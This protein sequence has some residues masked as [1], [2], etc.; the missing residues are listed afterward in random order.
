MTE[1]TAHATP[2]TDTGRFDG[3]P[4]N[5]MGYGAM[6]LAGLGEKGAPDPDTAVAVLRRA[7]AWGVNH[8]DTAEFYGD[9]VAND[10]IRAALLPY[11][12]DL[13]L[14]IKVGAQ[15]DAQR[16]LVP[17]QRPEQLRAGVEANLRRL[18]VERLAAVNLRRLE[19]I[20][21]GPGIEATGDQQVDLDSQLAELAALRE[22]GKI[23]GIG[24]SN[25][26]LEQLRQ[27]LPVGLVC[28]QNMYNLLERSSEPLLDECREHDLAFVPFFPLGSAFPGLPKVT[29]HPAVIAAATASKATPAQIGLAWLLAH[30]L[31]ILLIPGTSDPEHL[32]ENLDAADVHL[33]AATMATLD[34]L[35]TGSD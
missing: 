4:L 16:G 35:T 30:D 11:A 15:Y 14:V 18:G 5:R 21:P 20:G 33:D 34:N 23:G 27:A 2:S 9:G 32:E 7:V 19:S 25:V 29:E 28:V 24:L 6:Q 8:I 31:H 26:R 17:A 3:R 10:R 1:P 12:A 22:E 13:V